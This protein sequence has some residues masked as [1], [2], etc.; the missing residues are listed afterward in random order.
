MGGSNTLLGGRV[1]LVTGA[2]RGIGRAVAVRLASAG[3]DVSGSFLNSVDEA[4][5]TRTAIEATG[6]RAVMVRSDTTSRSAVRDHLEMTVHA[7]GRL[8]VVVIN[9]GILQQRPFRELTD[10]D[11]DR[12]LAVNLK[13]P[14][15]LCQEAMDRVAPGG[16][17]ILIG[18]IGGQVGG[19]LAV[20]YAA[21]KAAIIG[22]TRS[23]ARLLA[24]RVRVNCVAPGLVETEMTTGEIASEAGQAKIRQIPLARAG[25]ADEVAESVLFLASD[26]SSYVTGHTLNVNG[27][28]YLG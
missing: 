10:E 4:Q 20:H 3:A 6:R 1:A 21:T 26:A 14:M 16:C 27:G 13:G 17:I 8:D 24:P 19:T 18:S 28:L 5:V 12:M 2:S 15:V 25:L 23:M 7:F 9:A 11:L 22:L